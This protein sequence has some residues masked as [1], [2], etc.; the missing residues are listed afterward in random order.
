METVI[1][2]PEQLSDYP[3]KKDNYTVNTLCSA[4]TSCT[5]KNKNMLNV[6]TA[7]AVV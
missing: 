1:D 5:H 3:T 6:G 4:Q 7:T 2:F